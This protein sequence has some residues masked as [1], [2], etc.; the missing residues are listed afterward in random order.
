MKSFSQYGKL[1][2]AKPAW[3]CVCLGIVFDHEF[4][5]KDL[6]QG[7]FGQ[8]LHHLTCRLQINA[9]RLYKTHTDT[10][11][12]HNQNTNPKPMFCQIKFEKILKGGFLVGQK[13]AGHSLVSNRTCLM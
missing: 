6:G 3:H 7:N 8:N 2:Q 9:S 13:A 10:T 12:E 1:D 5:D 4:R 11:P